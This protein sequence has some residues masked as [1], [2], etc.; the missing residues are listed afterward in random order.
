MSPNRAHRGRG[1]TLIELLCAVAVAAILASIA[2]PSFQAVIHRARRCDALVAMMMVQL[3]EER[4]RA[5]HAVFGGL[6]EI[7]VAAQSPSRHY[8]L[9]MLSSTEMGYELQATATGAQASDANCRVLT[10]KM[11]GGNVSQSSASGTGAAN[12]AEV[13]RKCWSL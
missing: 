8:M 2:Y 3:A 4:H 9:A 5:N 6:D 12:S 13:N 10:L 11:D 1:F 7:G